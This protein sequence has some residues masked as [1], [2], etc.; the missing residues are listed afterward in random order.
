MT[1]PAPISVTDTPQALDRLVQAFEGLSP[2]NLPAL[3]ALYTA[4]ARFKDP[5]N[6]VQG[7]AAIEA[8]F[9]HMFTALHEPRFV[10]TERVQ[11]G[12]QVFLTWDFCFRFRRFDTVTP[13]TVRGASHLVFNEQGRVTLHR[14]YWDAAE[15][16]YEK[17]PLVGG[18]MRWLKRRANT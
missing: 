13:Q 3:V 18:L 14:D 11:Q 15:E 5:F 7:Q 2:D 16:L 9:R 1:A 10:V 12:S 6:E 4:D 8:I 17:L